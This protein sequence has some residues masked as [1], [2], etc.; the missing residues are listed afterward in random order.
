VLVIDIFAE[1]G[2]VRYKGSNAEVVQLIAGTNFTSFLTPDMAS[3]ND[4]GHSIGLSQ[5]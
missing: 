5:H 4:A 1:D 2:Q 3:K